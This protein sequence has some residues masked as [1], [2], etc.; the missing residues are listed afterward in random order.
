MPIA[1]GFK[2]E[3]K[4]DKLGLYYRKHKLLKCAILSSDLIL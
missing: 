4:K 1:Q 3:G 2:K